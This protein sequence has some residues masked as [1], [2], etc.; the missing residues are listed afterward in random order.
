MTEEEAQKKFCP[1]TMSAEQP[2]SCLGSMCMGWRWDEY[3]DLGMFKAGK[4]L[5]GNCGMVPIESDE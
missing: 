1:L 5:G 2:R 4:P 3:E